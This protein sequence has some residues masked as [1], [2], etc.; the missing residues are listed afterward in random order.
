MIYILFTITVL[1][2]LYN[3][4]NLFK[5]NLYKRQL[6]INNHELVMLKL[7]QN[8]F[9]CQILISTLDPEVEQDLYYIKLLENSIENINYI[10]G[11]VSDD[12]YQYRNNQ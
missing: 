4:Y 3:T 12:V 2:S 9:N 7:F 5:T 10:I 11:S 6:E 8:K 1:L